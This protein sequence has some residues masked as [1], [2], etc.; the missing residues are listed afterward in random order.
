MS[1]RE[2]SL[3]LEMVVR[4]WR[5]TGLCHGAYAGVHPP[6]PST[7]TQSAVCGWC[8]VNWHH[9][10]HQSYKHCL[11]RLAPI[12]QGNHC[13]DRPPVL[14]DHTSPGRQSHNTTWNWT[15][16]TKDHL[17][18]ETYFNVQWSFKT[19]STV[20]GNVIAASPVPNS[21]WTTSLTIQFP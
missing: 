19:G 8:P 9:L 10:C 2:M 18:C 5:G 3:S 12:L 7:P 14:K 11:M 21:L 1:Y 6:P 13:H 4:A 16:V 20:Q 17:S 15:C